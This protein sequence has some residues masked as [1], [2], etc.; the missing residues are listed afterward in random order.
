MASVLEI[1]LRM[2]DAD[3]RGLVLERIGGREDVRMVLDDGDARLDV[4]VADLGGDPAGRIGHLAGLLDRG[5]VRDVILLGERA[6]PEVLIQ[7]MRAGI[8]E[9]AALPLQ[10]GELED[11]LSRI[12]DRGSGSGQASSA[13]GEIVSVVGAAGGL[14]ATTLAV[15]LAWEL[16]AREPGSTVLVDL[17]RPHG[18]IPLFLDLEYSYTWGEVA[19]NITRMDQT[20]LRSV[21]AEGENGL[22]IL[23]AP[24]ANQW[25]KPVVS[26]DSIRECLN[27]LVEMYPH[28]VVEDN[29]G[30]DEVSQQVLE[31]SST[32]WLLMAMSVTCLARVKRHL[33]DAVR[34][35]GKNADRLRLAA[36][37]VVKGADIGFEEAAEAIGKPV[38]LTIPE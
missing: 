2:D 11:A 19:E 26:P 32:Q 17:R 29:S 3:L 38:S 7:A 20:F 30:L 35:D 31:A 22:R 23:P 5:S 4:V 27:G 14:G 10:A 33:D 16:Q 25:P 34:M 28:V 12:G 1:G 13:R 18:E 9:F 36:C 6:D 8:K 24:S 15:N 37:K 21:L